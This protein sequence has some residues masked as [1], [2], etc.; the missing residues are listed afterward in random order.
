MKFDFSK[1][2]DFGDIC[3][4]KYE[5]FAPKCNLLVKMFKS[6]N[7]MRISKPHEVSLFVSFPHEILRKT[8]CHMRSHEVLV[9]SVRA[10]S[11][12]NF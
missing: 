3:I 5:K 10:G 11:A 12:K 6:K 7:L 8:S 9:R 4:T 1:T 2:N